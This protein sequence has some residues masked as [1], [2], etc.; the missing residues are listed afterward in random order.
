MV[1]SISPT[2]RCP[3]GISDETLSA[4]RDAALD[5]RETE[6]LRIHAAECSS[7]RARLDEYETLGAAL[8]SERAPEPDERLWIELSER[9]SGGRQSSQWHV[10]IYSTPRRVF[11]GIGAVAAVLLL[12]LGFAALHGLI[13][14]N[15]P[16]AAP[17]VSATATSAELGTQP[18]PASRYITSAVTATSVDNHLAPLNP[19][20]RFTAGASVF[21][22][23]SVRNLPV[24]QL[25]TISVRWFFQG[26]PLDLKNAQTSRTVG[27]DANVYFSLTYSTPGVGMVKIYVDRPTGDTSDAPSDPHLGATVTFMIVKSGA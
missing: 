19:T 16:S 11:G 18:G 15:G 17:T 9:I 2:Q 14:S 12:A 25:H 1:M 5:A 23:I 8:R 26:V 13:G 3:I 10:P 22:A 20:S 7:C 6:R 4:W 24:G 27:S 21:V